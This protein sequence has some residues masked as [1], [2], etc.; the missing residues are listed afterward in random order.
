MYVCVSQISKQVFGLDA[1][2]GA[3]LWSSN[4]GS[5]VTAP[6]AIDSGGG[7]VVGNLNGKV[8]A[9]GGTLLSLLVLLVAT[10]PASLLPT[11]PSA[12]CTTAP[13]NLLLLRIII[14][15]ILLVLLIA[16][17]C[18]W[19]CVCRCIH[20]K[21]SSSKAD[22][23]VRSPPAPPRPVLPRPAADST[24]CAHRVAV[25]GPAP[26]RTTR[27]PH[28]RQRKLVQV[29]VLASQPRRTRST[30]RW[31][32]ARRL[33]LRRRTRRHICWTHPMCRE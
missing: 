9:I 1:M 21:R 29:Q 28:C 24:A 14:G 30:R 6:P 27:T 31:Q 19:C 10:V 4:L 18:C 11:P 13:F 32:W 5:Q 2:T 3:Q 16:F 15:A 22:N 8:F 12:C 25:W 23:T 17:C 7:V 33:R 20:R 26:Y